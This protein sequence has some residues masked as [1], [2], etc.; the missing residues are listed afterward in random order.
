MNGLKWYVSIYIA[1]YVWGKEQTNKQ[2]QKRL[3]PKPLEQTASLPYSQMVRNSLKAP[4]PLGDPIVWLGRNVY[5]LQNFNGP[6]HWVPVATDWI[7]GLSLIA[8][9][10]LKRITHSRDFWLSQQGWK[11]K[12]KLGQYTSL[13]LWNFG[14][15]W[16]LAVSD[17]CSFWLRKVC[18]IDWF[19][20][21]LHRV[22]RKCNQNQNL[23]NKNCTSCSKNVQGTKKLIRTDW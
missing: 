17:F 7:M 16:F 21:V 19:Y 12:L 15:T 3:I 1:F 20:L 6:L 13:T 9:Q 11:W 23:P 2:K 14:A 8:D 5:T 22:S 4:D 18:S 10:G